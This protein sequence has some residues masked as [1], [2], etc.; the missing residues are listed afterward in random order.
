[1]RMKSSLNF[2]LSPTSNLSSSLLSLDPTSHAHLLVPNELPNNTHPAL[3]LRQVRI[4]LL[5]Y[6]MQSR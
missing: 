4:K 2:L 6:L 1:M 3:M 5:R